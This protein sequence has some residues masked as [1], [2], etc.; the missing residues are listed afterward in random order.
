MIVKCI[1]SDKNIQK[2]SFLPVLINKE[3]Q[4][5]VITQK[6]KDFKEIMDYV[7]KIS[8][9]VGLDTELL[10]EGDEVVVHA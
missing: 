5:V 7:G 8:K 6:D 4:P 3:A 10:A 9:E 2:V 1:I